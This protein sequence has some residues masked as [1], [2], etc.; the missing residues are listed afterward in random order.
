MKGATLP[1]GRLVCLCA[2]EREPVETTQMKTVLKSPPLYRRPGEIGRRI[3]GSLFE[4]GIKAYGMAAAVSVA[5]SDS[6]T[7]GG[8]IHDA[9]AA[10]PNLMERYRQAKYVYDHAEEMQGALD[11]VH[12]HAPDARQL[13]TAVQKSY[14][15]LNGIRTM[16]TEISQAK[17]ALANIWINFNVLENAMQASEHVSRA[18]TALP[19][20]ESISHLTDVAQN[21][22]PFLKY[23]DILDI[24]FARIYGG[25]LS[26]MDNFASDEIAGTLGIMAAA[27]GIAFALGMGA[28]FWG[29]RGR[30]G[31]IISTLQ[32][33]GAR[34]FP[35]WYVRNLE[36]ALG[37][38]LYAVARERIQRDIVADPQAALDPEAHQEL[39]RYFER[40]L[41]EKPAATG[42]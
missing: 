3:T 29:R 35:D 6:E 41:R 28:G 32:G 7:V 16:L 37:R 1:A 9:L 20:L 2:M 19:D 21:V 36:A 10:L 8:K 17:E 39:E 4:L 22:P 42:F 31:I 15:A 5:L 40:R 30:P 38:P 25:L 26:V 13:E 34:L 27:F 14:E 23:L 18:W 33:W 24:D 11:Y 12:Q